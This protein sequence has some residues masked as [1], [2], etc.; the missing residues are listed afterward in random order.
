MA[1][2]SYYEGEFQHGE[3][4][5]HGFRCYADS[6]N[7]YSGEF[8]LGEMHGQ[9]IMK[10]GNGDKFEGEWYRNVR[11]GKSTVINPSLIF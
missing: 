3:I 11:Q 2:K 1:D 4:E 7:T 8:H 6:G 5:G 9:G 10:Y